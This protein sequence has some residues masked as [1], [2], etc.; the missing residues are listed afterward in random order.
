MLA[1]VGAADVKRY[2]LTHCFEES[3][4]SCSIVVASRDDDVVQPEPE[5]VEME[6]TTTTTTTTTKRPAPPPPPPSP[7]KPPA[8]QQ[9]R[10]KQQSML[11]ADL[12]EEDDYVE[13]VAVRAEGQPFETEAALKAVQTTLGRILYIAAR[14]DA[15]CEFAEPAS[16][17]KK[18]GDGQEV[19]TTP[20][21][22]VIT[23]ATT[24]APNNSSPADAEDESDEEERLQNRRKRAEEKT[25]LEPVV[26]ATRLAMETHMARLPVVLAPLFGVHTRVVVNK[27][28]VT[29]EETLFRVVPALFER[30]LANLR[31]EM[32]Q[33]QVLWIRPLTDTVVGR[34]DVS[35][36]AIDAL[37]RRVDS[38]SSEVRAMPKRETRDTS[39]WPFPPPPPR[40]EDSWGPEIAAVREDS[41]LSRY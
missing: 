40:K 12:D 34:L 25:L 9:T 8:M 5:P 35:T 24:P 2:N 29:F 14:L 27:T 22:V 13:E 39:N 38:L 18:G 36:A 17:A 3:M 37:G 41:A 32:M 30:S 26:N 1:Q 10:T 7:R 23:P 11:L 19:A 28:K 16:E 6:D 31:Q 15:Q 21:P 33:L 4:R 20:A